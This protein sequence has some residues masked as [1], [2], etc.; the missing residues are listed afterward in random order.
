MR[1]NILINMGFFLTL[2]ANTCL[3]EM[4]RLVVHFFF[5]IDANKNLEPLFLHLKLT[6]VRYQKLERLRES[7]ES[8]II[9]EEQSRGLQ[10]CAIYFF[11]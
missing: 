7:L 2:L 11:L 3:N 4:R 10:R 1:L 8:S 6:Y 9:T 5:T